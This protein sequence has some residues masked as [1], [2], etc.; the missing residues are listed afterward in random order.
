MYQKRYQ[1][2]LRISKGTP[3]PGSEKGEEHGT[4]NLK[5]ELFRE[6]TVTAM[7]D[8]QGYRRMLLTLDSGSYHQNCCLC[9]HLS[10]E[11]ILGISYLFMILSSNLETGT[12]TS[13]CWSISDVPNPGFQE[14]WDASVMDSF[15][16]H[17]G[18]WAC[19]RK[20]HSLSIGQGFKCRGD[21]LV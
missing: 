8:V 21:I 7:L 1:K 12:D 10:T 15:S 6:V 4:K 11:P 2:A 16:S 9:Q 19:H 17:H 5:T 3:V 13:D 18:R 14:R 20:Q